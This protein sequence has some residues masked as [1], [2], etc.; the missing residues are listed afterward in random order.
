MIYTAA[1]TSQGQL[2][3]PK[4]LRDRYALNEP[5]NVTLVEENNQIVIRPAPDF[6]SL[7]GSI[8]PKKRPEDWKAIDKAV[9]KAW[10]EDEKRLLEQEK[11][12][13]R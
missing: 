2:T 3:I 12:R 6:F 10:I 9:A 8:T 11:R 5:K 7:A 13:K 4:P 1:I